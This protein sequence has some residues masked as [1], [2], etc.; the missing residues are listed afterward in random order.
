MFLAKR[1]RSKILK[2]LK[3]FKVCFSTQFFFNILYS[4]LSFLKLRQVQ[5]FTQTYRKGFNGCI[6]IIQSKVTNESNSKVCSIPFFVIF[7]A[8]NAVILKTGLTSQ[9][10]ALHKNRLV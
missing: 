7:S 10:T 8:G 1:E 5:C 3:F 9:E 2:W 4:D 6:N